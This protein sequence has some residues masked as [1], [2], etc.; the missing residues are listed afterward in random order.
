MRVT[1]LQTPPG[2]A[3]RGFSALRG[4]SIPPRGLTASR[5][6]Q[7]RA[8]LGVTHLLF[9]GLAAR[10]LVRQPIDHVA[11]R[12]V[13]VLGARQLTQALATGKEPTV[14]VLLLGAEVD[15]AHAASMFA[16]ALFCRRWRHAALVDTALAAM[17]AVAGVA[18]A[19][20]GGRPAAR[21]GL[22][23]LPDRVAE[24]LASRLVPDRLSRGTGPNEPRGGRH[25]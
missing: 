15:I 25:A 9:P 2:S 13:R 6:S 19:R 4:R 23:V 16:L 11:R 5:L 8:G 20:A 1:L 3:A 7:L 12:V 24:R 21:V 10:L 18:A 17:F 22:R 14:A